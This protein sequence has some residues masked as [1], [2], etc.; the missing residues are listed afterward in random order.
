MSNNY[1]EIV[2]MKYKEILDDLYD[3]CRWDRP[4]KVNDILQANANKKVDIVY[5][6]GVLLKI[7]LSGDTADLLKVLLDYYYIQHNLSLPIE[8]YTLEQ[9]A[10]KHTL[11]QI[12]QD[13]YVP[14][15]MIEFLKG[16]SINLNDDSSSVGDFE[17][18][19]EDNMVIDKEYNS[20]STQHHTP[21]KDKINLLQDTNDKI[22]KETINEYL[23]SLIQDP[24]PEQNLEVNGHVLNQETYEL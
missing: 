1:W 18:E 15:E 16:Y 10:A 19:F 2:I 4:E 14:E 5:D 20:G 17:E 12:L 7:A 24:I 23:V 21:E 3:Y 6:K 22:T 13:T 11:Y 8:H 9:S